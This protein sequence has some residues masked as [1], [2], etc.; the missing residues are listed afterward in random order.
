MVEGGERKKMSKEQDTKKPGD[1]GVIGPG[2]VGSALAIGLSKAGRPPT[3]IYG[4]RRERALELAD[5]IRAAVADSVAEV[6]AGVKIILLTAPDD[7]LEGLVQ[8]ISEA[9]TLFPDKIF[10]HTSGALGSE[11]LSPLKERGAFIASLHP[12]QSIADRET[13]WRL[14]AGSWFALEGDEEAVREGRSLVE[15]LAG[16]SLELKTGT[17]T[18]YHAAACVASNFLI[19]IEH[20]ASRMLAQSGIEPTE[21]FLVIEP[22][23]RGTINNLEAK[24][25]VQ[26]LTGPIARGDLGTVRRHLKEIEKTI[27]AYL[28]FYKVMV[29]QTVEVALAQGGLDQ[30]K[31]N[32]LLAL[33]TGKTMDRG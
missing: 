12:L 20:I 5:R 33:I 1:I 13:G 2:K 32:E 7:S 4:P 23:I 29:R 27:P 31:A 24:G 3:L 8:E 22:L 21:F 10:Y 14:L 6:I 19:T 30:G 9:R 15:S 11:I 25:P 18:L 16:R 28:E 17:K 26:A